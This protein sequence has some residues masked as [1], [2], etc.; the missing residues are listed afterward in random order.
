MGE[1]MDEVCDSLI[2]ELYQKC[3]LHCV[4]HG[5]LI[6]PD[7]QRLTLGFITYK[8]ITTEESKEMEASA[9]KRFVEIINQHE[10]IRP[11]LRDYPWNS[12]KV[13]IEIA[14]KDIND[15]VQYVDGGEVSWAQFLGE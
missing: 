13:T 4:S 7:V 12:E 14:F 5:T 9:V 2:E 10:K 6:G 3:N 1:S 8:Q 11:F 15:D